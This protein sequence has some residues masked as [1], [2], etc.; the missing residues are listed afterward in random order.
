MADFCKACS[1]ELY[2]KDLGDFANITTE[3]DWKEGRA[4]L[5]M[6]EGCG[7]IQVDPNGRC[8][9]NC[10]KNEKEGHGR[11]NERWDREEI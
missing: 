4:A 6:C 11:K 3:D 9:G 8:I 5:V 10:F 7:P 1:I 2:E